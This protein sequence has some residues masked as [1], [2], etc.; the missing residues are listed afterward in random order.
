MHGV[1]KNDII[2][3]HTIFFYSLG[4]THTYKKFE[5]FGKIA[6]SI[7]RIQAYSHCSTVSTIGAPHK[8]YHTFTLYYVITTHF[9]STPTLLHGGQKQKMH[10]KEMCQAYNLHTIQRNDA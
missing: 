10:Q 8:Y 4:S 2:S 6:F 1:Y 7:F 5:T 3:F 9:N